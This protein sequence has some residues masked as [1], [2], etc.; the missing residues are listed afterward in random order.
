MDSKFTQLEH[1]D[2]K[3]IRESITAEQN[4]I[5]PIMNKEIEDGNHVLDH[6]HMTKSETRGV[7]GAGTIRGVLDFRSNSWEGKVTNSFKRSGLSKEIDLIEALRNLADYLERDSYPL[8]HPNEKIKEK[9]LLKRPFN[10]IKKMYSKEYPKRKTLT[11]PK[12]GKATVQIKELS[13][14]Y[15]IDI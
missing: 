13:K 7:N 14:K 3:I 12:S 15:N 10:K 1:K 8:I 2:I 6:Q 11:Y 4:N 9:K 5:C